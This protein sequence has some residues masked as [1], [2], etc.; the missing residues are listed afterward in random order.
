MAGIIAALSQNSDVDAC[1]QFCN[2]ALSATR[3][4]GPAEQKALLERLPLLLHRLLYAWLGISN[5][6]IEEALLRTFRPQGPVLSHIIAFKSPAFVFPL[7]R[8]PP[9]AIRAAILS[10]A[11]EEGCSGLIQT[12]MQGDRNTRD[13]ILQQRQRG[14]DY[15]S[16]WFGLLG[17]KRLARTPAGDVEGVTL[18]AAEYLLTCFVHYLV[19]EQPVHPVAQGA[20]SSGLGSG[21]VG[22]GLLQAGPGVNAGG[23][24]MGGSSL[25]WTATGSMMGTVAGALGNRAARPLGTLSPTFERLLLAHLRALLRHTEYELAYAHEP[26][27]A[28]FLLHLLHEFLVAP[29]PDSTVLPSDM[30]HETATRARDA[31]SRPAALHAMRL[32]AIHVLANPALRRGCEEAYSGGFTVGSGRSARLTREV[33]LLAPPLFGLVVELL[34]GIASQRQAGLETLTSLMRLWLVLLQPWKARRLHEWYSSVRPDEPRLEPPAHTLAS[35]IITRLHR[36]ADVALLG[37]EPEAPPGSVEAPVPQVPDDLI[38]TAVDLPTSVGSLPVF[39]TGLQMSCPLVPGDG[40]AES[41]RSYVARFHQGYCLLESFLTAPLHVELCL[42]LCRHAAGVSMVDTSRT[43]A[44]SVGEAV[45]DSA[46]ASVWGAFGGQLSLHQLLRQRHVMVSLKVLGQALLCF[47]EPELMRVMA[48]PPPR[49]NRLRCPLAL[50]VFT[51]DGSLR[52]QLVLMVS[53]AWAALLAARH[54]YELQPLLAAISRQLEHC[55]QWT[56][57]KLPHPDSVEQHKPFAKRILEEF[58]RQFP[59]TAAKSTS[60]AV[61]IPPLEYGMS[62]P[63]SAAFVGSEWQRP[64]RGGELELL[65]QI[66]Y[67]LARMIDQL[68]GRELRSI[69]CGQVPQTEWPRMFANWKLTASMVLVIAWAMF[70]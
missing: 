29:Q 45:L 69:S 70:W 20:G 13:N 36:N 34:E 3:H 42:Q 23:S 62:S 64:V 65:L 44:A 32:V 41:W 2:E 43:A 60:P 15:N 21:S 12:M 49:D 59:E 53:L 25:A 63:H 47:T 33:G 66:A 40:D 57:Y 67:W 68:L 38:A 50:P 58:G 30:Q 4:W 39:G 24:G 7:K 31:R 52:S 22:S 27:E 6:G 46:A 48:S 51:D 37:L 5:A 9:R 28:R 35:G 56:T 55:P 1:R 19:C 26:H 16:A 11:A 18:S 8:L 54:H 14:S 17:A 10:A 61:A